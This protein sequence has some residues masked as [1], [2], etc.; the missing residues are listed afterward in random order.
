LHQGIGNRGASLCRLHCLAIFEQLVH[1]VQR[2][3]DRK[4]CGINWTLNSPGGGLQHGF[5]RD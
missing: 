3:L 2:N 5:A 1:D 4:T